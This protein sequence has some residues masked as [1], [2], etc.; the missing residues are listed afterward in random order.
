MTGE[1]AA[2]AKCGVPISISAVSKTF[3]EETDKPFLALR[4][5]SVEIQAGEFV[6]VVGPSGCGKSTLMLMVAGCSGAVMTSSWKF[7]DEANHGRWYC[8][9]DHLLDFRMAGQCHRHADI[10]S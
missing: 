6:S 2:D 1:L 10:R 3:G 9:Q 4:E 5:V 8:L 7:R